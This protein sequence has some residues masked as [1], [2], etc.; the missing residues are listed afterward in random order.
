MLSGM[1]A[2]SELPLCDTFVTQ[3]TGCRCHACDLGGFLLTAARGFHL[4]GLWE[5]VTGSADLVLY[6][7]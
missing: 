7:H 4:V 1:L 6:R 5:W 3:A 2:D